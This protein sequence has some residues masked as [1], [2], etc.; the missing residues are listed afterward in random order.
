[1]RKLTLKEF[2]DRV[3]KAHPKEQLLVI[4][5]TSRLEDCEV[6]CLKC[7]SIY[8]KKGYNFL[9]GRKVSICKKCFPTQEGIFEN[10]YI[11]PEGYTLI[12]PYQ[13]AH[14]NILVRHKCGFIW[15][16]KPNNLNFGKGCPKCR[17]KKSKGEQKI[18][19]YL[20][21]NQIE[22][23][24][25]IPVQLEGHSLTMDFYLPD[26]DLYIE[27]NGEQHY[28]PIEHFGGIEKF[29]KQIENDKL[30]QRHFN[31]LLIISYLDFDKID[32]ILESSTT[33]PIGSRD[34]RPEVETI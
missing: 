23:K 11:P 8:I 33:I 2:Q 19:N 20:E 21:D 32:Q 17:K 22:Y 9:D 24:F 12:E 34:K 31:N 4:K 5:Y 10:D 28:R 30:K 6:K 3:N 15:K 29:N 7:N 18:I 26:F 25:Q 1:M 13:G 14:K 16:V 27:Y